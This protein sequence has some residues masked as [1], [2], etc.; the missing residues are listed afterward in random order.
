MSLVREVSAHEAGEVL[1][2][3]EKTREKREAAKIKPFL[4]KERE[5]FVSFF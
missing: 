2:C 5:S 1:R 4:S 3:H